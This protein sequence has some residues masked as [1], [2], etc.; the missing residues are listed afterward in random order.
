MAANNRFS[1]ADKA[2][3]LLVALGEEIAADLFKAMD[4]HEVRVIAAAINRLGKLDKSTI[5]EVL[6]EFLSILNGK[7]VGPQKDPAGFAQRALQLAFKG[8]HGQK[9]AQQIGKGAVKLRALE[10]ADP[11]TLARVLQLE[12]PQTVAMVL[13]HATA[14]KASLV[15]R[16]MPEALRTEILLRIAKLNPIDPDI[17]AEIDQH[18][19]NEIEKMGSIGQR[20]I[21]GAKKVAEILN[22]MDKKG[23]EILQGIESR[24]SELSKEIRQEMFT[25]EDLVYLDNRG[26][27]ELVKSVAR[28][29][30]ILALR[31]VDEKLLQLFSRSMSERA[32]KIMRDDIDALGSQKQSAV[33]NAQREVLDHVQKLEAEG[34]IVIERQQIVS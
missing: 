32:A 1:P 8:E 33:Q 19:L 18:L 20:K 17:V 28:N 10:V 31:G 22:R 24:S 12:H 34:K 13:A 15:L 2:A 27:Q 16:Q 30:L 29:V 11:S 23:L 5:D 26:L 3:I 6:V 25:F 21:G 4:P 9:L 7:S 14:D